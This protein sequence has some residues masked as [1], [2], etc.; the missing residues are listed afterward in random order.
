MRFLAFLNDHVYDW[1]AG[2][3]HLAPRKSAL[4]ALADTQVPQRENYAGT[5]DISK[6]VPAIVNWQAVEDIL[7]EENEKT[8][9]LGADPA[10]VLAE[11]DARINTQLNR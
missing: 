4:K 3:G 7:K 1:S 6:L 5:A 10:T 9:L 11:A 8:W 2:T